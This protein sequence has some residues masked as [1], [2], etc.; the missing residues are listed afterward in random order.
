MV[1]K[2]LSF[3]S[4]NLILL[5]VKTSSLELHIIDLVGSFL[6]LS[7]IAF[8]FHQYFFFNWFHQ[9]LFSK[10]L[11]KV[12]IFGILLELAHELN[13]L[14]GV[15]LE[16]CKF[17]IKASFAYFYGLSDVRLERELLAG[18]SALHVPTLPKS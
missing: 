16:F 8:M 13:I 12:L 4:Q 15:Y 9:K 5:H 17:I 3:R 14:E 2:K 6:K 11:F 1:C 10:Y 18:G 7:K